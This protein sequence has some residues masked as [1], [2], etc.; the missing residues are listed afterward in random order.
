MDILLTLGLI[1][2]FTKIADSIAIRFGLPSVVGSLLVGIIVG[3]SLLNIFQTN[4]SIELFSHI[5]VVLLM[6]LAGVES[7]LKILQKYFKPSLYTGLLGVIVPFITFF[8]CSKV[9]QFSTETSLFIGLIFGATSLS[10]TVQVL[11]ELH[12]MQT[13]E[14]SVIIGAAVLDDIIVVIFLNFILNMLDPATTIADMVPLLIKNIL[15]FIAIILIDKFVMPLCLKLLKKTKVPEKNVAFSLMLVFL[16][17]YLADFIGMSDIIGAFFAGIL[18]SRTHFAHLVEMKITSITLSMFAPVFFVSIGLNLVLD[19]M[20]NNL[21][22]L[23]VFSVLAVITKFVGG[24]LGGKL[25]GFDTIS[26]SIVGA[27]LVSRGEMALILISLGLE[28]TFINEEI[29]ASLVLVIIFTT[30]IAPII[31]KYF[32]SKHPSHLDALSKKKTN[33]SHIEK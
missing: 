24:Y 29:Y 18:I 23:I 1:I 17:S 31:L 28:K 16:L 15:F 21:L 32:I 26:S 2:L 22:L 25:E 19:N 33:L 5:G 3:P 27:S 10:I 6:F 8:L 12:F 11:K 30:I 20:M 4:H 13:K 9:F 7:D 14:G